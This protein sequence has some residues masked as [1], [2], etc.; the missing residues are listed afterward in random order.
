MAGK[1]NKVFVFGYV[2]KSD[3]E[4]CSIRDEDTE[5]LYENIILSKGIT[6]VPKTGSMAIACMVPETDFDG[7]LVFADEFEAIVLAG[8]ENEGMIKVVEL[9]DKL[10]TIETELNKLK[11]IFKAWKPPTGTPDSGA[12][13]KGA[14][15]TWFGKTLQL[16][17]QKD[18]E[19][20]TVKH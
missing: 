19:N 8:G 3:K 11:N 1:Q 2:E 7:F 4:K 13:L 6:I 12:A 16:T 5:T 9:K 17:K 10:N 14:L 20:E 18:I 15:A